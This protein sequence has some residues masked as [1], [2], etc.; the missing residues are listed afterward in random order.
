MAHGTL[1][2]LATLLS[3]SSTLCAQER[4]L[5]SRVQLS[6]Y[7]S[8]GEP[9]EDWHLTAFKDSN[10][11]D[12]KRHFRNGTSD[13]IPFG[14]F[15]VR[16]ESG[17]FLPYEGRVSVRSSRTIYL[18]GLTFSGIEN[19]PPNDALTGKFS[20]RPSPGTWCKLSGIYTPQTYFV[21]VDDNGSFEFPWVNSGLYIL[22]CR[23]ES[24]NLILRDVEVRHGK[25]PFVVVPA[26]R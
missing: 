25:T 4:R 13:E 20:K 5:V 2:L 24:S 9:V 16:V 21:S 23:N 6:F 11:R 17:M 26:G 8:F 14:D 3:T 1:L 18:V 10:G 12:W 7:N 19:S 15:V 22:L